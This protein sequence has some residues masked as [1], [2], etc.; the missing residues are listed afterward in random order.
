[1]TSGKRFVVVWVAIAALCAGLAGCSREQRDW[2]SAQSAD[3]LEAY[4][5]FL[6][7]HPDGQLATQ[8]RMRLLQ[9]TEER[10]WQ[11]ASTSDTADAY[12][13]FL[14]QHPS[15]KWSQEARIRSENFALEGQPINP[16]LAAAP[17]SPRATT[18]SVSSPASAQPRGDS[19]GRAVASPMS[20]SSSASAQ[21]RAD[22]TAR[23]MAAP[24]S[25]SNS[26]NA[27]PHADDTARAAA[28]PM[29]EHAAASASETP[30]AAAV[31]S[32]AHD[33]QPRVAPAATPAAPADDS[34]PRASDSTFGIQLGAFS[35]ESKANSE[36]QRLQSQFAAELGSLR[37][38]IVSATTSAGSLFRLQSQVESEARARAICASLAQK[39]QGCVVV[40][41]HH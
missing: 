2:R 27:Q 23:A 9:L 28:A 33:S 25:A 12:K 37:P 30:R 24:M 4:D 20:A 38:H 26:A 40:L 5:Q 16:A 34:T 13:R 36:W 18:P 3:S 29:S 31:G 39:S 22:D 14:N 8:A 21:P 6:E 10:D 17:S 15:G 41:P 1:M 19:V 7:R 35:T 32:P 11:R